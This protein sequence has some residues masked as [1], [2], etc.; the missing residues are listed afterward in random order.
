[1]LAKNNPIAIIAVS[2][3]FSIFKN[4]ALGMEQVA[5]V[6]SDLTGVLLAAL[7]LFITGREFVPILFRKRKH[8]ILVDEEVK[9]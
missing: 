7:I 3:V 6:P 9:Q 5:N 2:F 1:M 8:V 4:G